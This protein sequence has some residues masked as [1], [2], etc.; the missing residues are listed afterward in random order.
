MPEITLE[1][2]VAP[3]TPE[4]IAALEEYQS[5]RS[6]WGN[7]FHPYTCGNHSHVSLI[8]T[9][10]GWH[11]SVPECDYAQTWAYDPLPVQGKMKLAIR[12]MLDEGLMVGEPKTHER[13]FWTTRENAIL[14]ATYPTEGLQ[15][16]V[17]L[18]P[19][20]T[21]GSIYQHASLLDLLSPQEHR[22]RQGASRR[23]TWP[24]TPAIDKA[25][26]E[27]ISKATRPRDVLKLA[28]SLN[29]PRWWV[30][31]RAMKLGCKA[32]RF[33]QL[34]W[35]EAELDIVRNAP[36]LSPE[37]LKRHLAHAGFER[38]CTAIVIKLKRLHADRQDPNHCTANALAG[39]MGVDPHTVTSW[40]AK[41]LLT[42]KYRG[43]KQIRPDD[44]QRD[45]HWIA[46]V[47]VRT[48]I[49]QYPAHIDIRKV[50]KFWF[51]DLL[52]GLA[53]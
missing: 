28:Q 16:C 43:N 24:T 49:V 22:Q 5:G 29:R 50:D 37:T 4:Q 46:Y 45:Y 23:Q 51:I 47:D 39:F 6:S 21:A 14:K 11:C 3:W 44:Q 19:G 42:A 9:A 18:L 31:N 15:A 41:G 48:F 35:T 12:E 26:R 25:I 1:T 2:I 8:P 40:I 34:P 17:P 20:R 7:I 10:S 30:S 38:T 53:R 32:P 36:H 27:G 33:K 13:R 52:G